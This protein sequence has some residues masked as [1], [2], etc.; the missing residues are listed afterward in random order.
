NDTFL[1]MK[2]KPMKDFLFSQ[3]EWSSK[4]VCC[5]EIRVSPGGM[6]DTARE[7]LQS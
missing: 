7:A 1:E 2:N 3:S 5:K 6:K 4:S